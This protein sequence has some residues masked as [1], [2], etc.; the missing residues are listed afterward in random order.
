MRNGIRQRQERILTELY[1]QQEVTVKVLALKMGASEATI[2][3][4]L[5]SM[6]QAGQVVLSY[7]GAVLP[8]NTNSSYRSKAT[9]NV[10]AKRI[11]GKLAAA[12]VVEGEQI[13]LDSG[14][15]CSQLVPHLRA[16]RGLSVIANSAR[17]M[18]ELE[19]PN[20]DAILIGGQYRHDRMDTV[21][22]LA[23]AA[24]EQLHGYLAF[25]GADGLSMDHGLTANDIE[26]AFLFRC[27][28]SRAR[29][30]ILV[31]DHTKFEAPSLCKVVGWDAIQTVVTDRL[32]SPDWQKFFA[33]RQ[34]ELV[35]PDNLD[36]P[37]AD[38]EADDKVGREGVSR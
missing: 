23:Q 31:A 8:R 36:N 16:K 22:P 33:E 14:S 3:R 27:A 12:L 29:E 6:A 7:G 34:I 28:A 35:V 17:L 1:E 2:R 20:V 9:R 32:P 5:R 21:G 37:E 10:E 13:F 4:D 38:S 24:L 30:V 11:I 15:T 26:S 25:L 19:S 18:L